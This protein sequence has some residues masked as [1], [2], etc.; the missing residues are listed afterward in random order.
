MLVAT[1]D[2][3]L[4]APP[5]A[6]GL[7]TLGCGP[8]RSPP[9]GREST[10]GGDTPEQGGAEPRRREGDE[11]EELVDGNRCL[12]A[13]GAAGEEDRGK[14]DWSVTLSLSL[15]LDGKGRTEVLRHR[16]GEE[17]SWEAEAEGERRFQ[18]DLVNTD[19]KVRYHF[20]VRCEAVSKHKHYTE[21][22]SKTSVTS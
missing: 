22:L 16:G 1:S 20:P 2:P 4:S 8:G 6:P 7:I 13:T 12:V 10:E 18:S 5:T 14:Y 19:F 3:P 15:G 17:D 21:T 11:G 9:T